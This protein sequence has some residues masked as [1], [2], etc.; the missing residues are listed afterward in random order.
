M[1]NEPHLKPKISPK[2]TEYEAY[3]W[4]EEFNFTDG[5]ARHHSTAEIAR[6]IREFGTEQIRQ[7]ELENN[8][9]YSYFD[10]AGQNGADRQFTLYNSSASLSIEI[11]A[12]Y[13]RLK[14]HSVALIEPTFDNIS[15]IFKRHAVQCIPIPEQLFIRIEELE[16][17][18]NNGREFDALFVVTPN[19]PT[20]FTLDRANFSALVDFCVRHNVLLIADFTFRFYSVE[21]SLW[22]QY[23]IAEYSG[24][25]YIFIEDTGKTWPSLEI[26]VSPLVASS[27]IFDEVKRIFLDLFICLS[28]FN[29]GLLT[30]IIA[31]SS[32]FDSEYGVLSI[33]NRNRRRLRDS[34][35]GA[36]LIPVTTLGI[37]VEWVFIDAQMQDVHLE[38]L[39][40]AYGIFILP[41]RNFFWSDRNSNTQFMRVAL[42]REEETFSRGMARF[43]DAIEQ[44]FISSQQT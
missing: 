30:R 6:I 35:Y 44:I 7:D 23:S 40:S 27:S 42:M 39:L 11:V 16:E 29:F 26:K 33:A 31:E 14:K 21:M 34:L 36:P 10:L 4:E 28:P 19:N 20:G 22:D 37:P 13:L 3:A 24:V 5:H 18:W 43:S 25:S 12:N 32:A 8:F 1:Q 17:L 38:R 41:G 15:D 2:L 9:H